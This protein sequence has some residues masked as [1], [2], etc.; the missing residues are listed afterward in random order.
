MQ[1]DLRA[2]YLAYLHVRLS[3]SRVGAVLGEGCATYGEFVGRATSGLWGGE[4]DG[5][6]RIGAGG[7]P[8]D[9]CGFVRG[10]VGC[11]LGQVGASVSLEGSAVLADSSAGQECGAGG[12]GVQSVVA[13]GAFESVQ[14]SCG[15]GGASEVRGGVVPVPGGEL[16][17]FRVGDGETGSYQAES[18]GEQ[19]PSVGAVSGVGKH[20]KRNRARRGR[21]KA[22]RRSTVEVASGVRQEAADGLF[23]R[24]VVENNLAV[25]VA[26]REL[27]RLSAGGES[28]GVPEWRRKAPK[29][30]VH[31]GVFSSCSEVVQQELVDTR[32]RMLVARNRAAEV[33]AEADRRRLE[34]Q[35][36]SQSIESEV[37][38]RRLRMEKEYVG[39]AQSKHDAMSVGFAETVV[40]SGLQSVISVP[41]LDGSGS[42]S[43]DSSVSV[44]MVK[45]MEGVISCLSAKLEESQKELTAEKGK[46][47]LVEEE[48]K[49]QVSFTGGEKDF[50]LEDRFAAMA[51]SGYGGFSR[52]D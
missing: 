28:D 14:Q 2:M 34:A 48:K 20:N 44:A 52:W 47:G 19:V 42:V 27:A 36:G 5:C 32:A 1:D 10:A 13:E 9:A 31:K 46:K 51:G 6:L 7:V 43:P 23:Q 4:G 8:E 49:S 37:E 26:Q 21:A 38:V 15:A 33:K 18:S 35:L 24:R 22:S 16:G 11:I 17:Q 41:S 50:F 25:V 39:L 3:E 40:S 30:A 12:G 45:R 29:A